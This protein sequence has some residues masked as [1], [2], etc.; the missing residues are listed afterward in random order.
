ML[1]WYIKEG[2]KFRGFKGSSKKQ[3]ELHVTYMNHSDS[4]NPSKIV[5]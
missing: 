5:K 4:L 1:T 2:S 3:Q